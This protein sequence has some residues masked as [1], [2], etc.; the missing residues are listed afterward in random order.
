MQV[1]LDR[2]QCQRPHSSCAA[3]F[4]EHLRKVDFKGAPCLVSM[5][6][7]GRPVI[8]FKIYDRDG[9]IKVLVVNPFNRRQAESSWLKLW[10]VQAGPLI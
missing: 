3:C 1:V 4:G 9:S 2:S 5:V 10:E 6:R 8:V 7:E